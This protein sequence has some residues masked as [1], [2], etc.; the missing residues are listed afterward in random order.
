MGHQPSV[1]SPRT[2]RRGWDKPLHEKGKNTRQKRRTAGGS[3][4]EPTPTVTVKEVWEGTL[5]RLHVLGNQRF[6]CSPFSEHFDRWLMNL[7]DVLNEFESNPNISVDEQFVKETSQVL[8]TIKLQ[9]EE[10]RRKEASTEADVKS[11]SDGKTLL[12]QI[13]REY[14]IVAGELKARRNAEVKRLYSS[15][16]RLRKE[17]D[18]I[19]RVKAGFLR[20]VSKK[21]REQKEVQ[22]AHKFTQIHEI[23][24]FLAGLLSHL[25]CL[26]GSAFFLKHLIIRME[27]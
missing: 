1:K 23:Q 11:L 13:K 21:E 2:P 18:E 5:K 25:H 24:L 22:I 15:I 12:E 27:P 8:S 19:I 10:K 14:A 9:L 26:Q 20:R 3:A 7:A 16:N 4:V 6:G 17:L